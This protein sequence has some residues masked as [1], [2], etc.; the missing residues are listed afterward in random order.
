MVPTM[1]E[2]TS[3]SAVVRWNPI[4]ERLANGKIIDYVV[5]YRLSES[6]HRMKRQTIDGMIVEECINGGAGNA[7]RN[8]TVDGDQ[9]SATLRYLS[10]SIHLL[11]DTPP[12]LEM[13]FLCL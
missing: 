3:T 12:V 9:T 1:D 6:V 11:W 4:P 8:M 5:N 7:D 2:I 10:K 13:I